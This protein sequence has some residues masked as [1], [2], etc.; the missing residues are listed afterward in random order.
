MQY[1]FFRISVNNSSEAEAELNRFLR[2]PRILAVHREFVT[3]GESSFWAVAVEYLFGEP[4][5]EK[6]NPRRREKIDY[7]EVLEPGDFAVYARLRD[8]RKQTGDAEAVPVYTILTNEQ[9][10]EIARRR[11]SSLAALGEISGIGAGRLEKYGQ[12]ILDLLQLET[13]VNEAD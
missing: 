11:C 2:G 9:M 12:Q 13:P 3:Q 8:W 4:P 5:L 7:K 6:T 1:K 10:A